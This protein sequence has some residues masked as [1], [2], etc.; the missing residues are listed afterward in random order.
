MRLSPHFTLKELTHSQTA[1]RLSIDNDPDEVAIECLRLVCHELLEAVREKWG[2]PF[3]PSSGFRSIELNE[4]IGSHAGSQHILGQAVDF[5]IPGVPNLEVARWISGNCKFDQLILEFYQEETP[6]SG[7][8]HASIVPDLNR[9]EKMRYDGLMFY[10]GF[11]DE[12]DLI[13]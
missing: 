4:A 8:V 2:I 3:S 11:E 12:E 5:E 10:H 1:L 13:A 6:N 9:S 7:W